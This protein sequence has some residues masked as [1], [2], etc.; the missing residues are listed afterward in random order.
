MRKILLVSL[1]ATCIPAFALP[2]TCPSTLPSLLALGTGSCTVAGLGTL[3][4]FRFSVSSTNGGSPWTAA[5]SSIGASSGFF[6]A[7]MGQPAASGIGS[8]ISTSTYNLA[9]NLVAPS[10]NTITGA[11]FSF[12]YSSGA[13]VTSTIGGSETLCPNGLFTGFPPTACSGTTQTLTVPTFNPQTQSPQNP[14]AIT[15]SATSADVLVT[16]TG[17]GDVISFGGGQ[18]FTI[19]PIATPTPTPTPPPA[20]TP[21]PPSL[22]LALTGL[23]CVGVY[24]TWR[25][26]RRA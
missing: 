25:K 7:V 22:L 14:A 18:L 24:L 1:A 19:T 3:S 16:G 10:G 20:A 9:F 15:F 6:T 2:Q 21:A 13:L 8:A 5:L 4:N 12:G 23:G 26:A 17:S 11:S